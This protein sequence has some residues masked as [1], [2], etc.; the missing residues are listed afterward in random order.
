MTNKLLTD[1]P[2]LG[3][4]KPLNANTP[5]E[6]M[7]A[8]AHMM[9]Q[10][11]HVDEARTEKA[12]R[13]LSDLLK[14]VK[15]D[16]V[17]LGNFKNRITRLKQRLSKAADGL[18]EV[19]LNK[20]LDAIR[21]VR[22]ALL[23]RLEQQTLTAEELQLKIDRAETDTLKLRALLQEY[24]PDSQNRRSP[25]PFRVIQGGRTRQKLSLVH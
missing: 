1:L 21:T 22:D 4:A 15:A 17:A 12:R 16:R 2:Q 7:A 25:W 23:D 14:S 6:E 5:T 11:L 3:D 9:R 24:A 8:M 19:D 13:A 18:E 10:K 20:Q